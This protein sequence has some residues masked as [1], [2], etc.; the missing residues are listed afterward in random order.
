MVNIREPK[1]DR[2]RLTDSLVDKNDWLELREDIRAGFKG[3][4][5]RQDRTNGRLLDVEKVQ[6][7]H[8]ENIKE[9]QRILFRRRSARREGDP[10]PP[11]DEKTSIS[12]R[13]VKIVLGTAGT[14]W[15][16]FKGLAWL[17]PFLK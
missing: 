13:D 16:G 12:Q 3:V 2:R 7:G 9:I 15:A 1:D 10:P 11:A 8:V 6:T 17:I 5:E 4:H 14:V